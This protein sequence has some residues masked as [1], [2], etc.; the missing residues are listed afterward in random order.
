[1]EEKYLIENITFAFL[2]VETTG[3]SPDRGDKICEI[4]LLKAKNGDVLEE[5]EML[6]DPGR[7]ISLGASQVSGIT[8]DMLIGKPSFEQIAEDILKRLQGVVIVCHNAPFDMGFL[9]AELAQ[10]GQLYPYFTV[11]DSLA[12]ARNKYSF[13]SNK[14]A[15]IAV[16]LGVEVK[17]AHRALGDCIILK[18]VFY[19]FLAD[20]KAQGI[21]TLDKLLELQNKVYVRNRR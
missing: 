4:G 17:R 15:N 19:K 10:T 11:V 12:I 6:L 8:Q 14:L 21:D 9:Q 2:D 1:M 20:F 16:A 13:S 7:E 3:L 18:E 5:Y